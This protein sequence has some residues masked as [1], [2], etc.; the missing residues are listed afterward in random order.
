MD[1]FSFVEQLIDELFQ[2]SLAAYFIYCIYPLSTDIRST[3]S[4]P[5][6][7]REVLPIPLKD[8]ICAKSISLI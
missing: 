7:P 4:L 8:L 3:D 5:K 1:S 6:Q 2:L